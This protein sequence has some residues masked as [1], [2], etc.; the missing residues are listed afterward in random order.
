MNCPNCGACDKFAVLT[1]KASMSRE[2]NH[3]QG[4]SRCGHCDQVF[5]WDM[6]AVPINIVSGIPELANLTPAPPWAMSTEVLQ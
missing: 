3:S 6:S 4:L 1:V 2:G 5:A